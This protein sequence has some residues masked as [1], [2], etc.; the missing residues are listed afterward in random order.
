VNNIVKILRSFLPYGL[1]AWSR[2]RQKAKNREKRTSY[3]T[4]NS[5]KIFYITGIVDKRGGLFWML[6]YNLSR[7]AY[8]LEKGWIPVVDWQNRPNQYL[9]NE[10]LYKENAWEYYF[11]QPCNYN[12]ASINRSKNII[13]DHRIDGLILDYHIETNEEYFSYL[14]AIFKK[15]IRFN[16]FTHNYIEK[17]YQTILK[18][19]DKILGVLCRGTDYMHKKPDGHPI[20]PEPEKVIKKAKEVMAD[21]QLDYIYL[22][23]EDQ[24]IYEL[25]RN[26]F[27]EKVLTNRQNRFTKQEVAK[28]QYLYQIKQ[29][30]ENDKYWLG[31]EYLSSMYLLSKC[32]S[33]ISGR[34]RGATGVLL[35]TDGFDYRYIWNLGV[36]IDE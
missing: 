31:L 29:D 24:D 12:L 22:A 18:D 4:E 35:M 23:T 7:I 1:V 3:G 21:Q 36:Y 13:Q 32:N 15:Y 8:A 17:E 16:E 11:E 27:G 28:V 19:K 34:T 6:L 33:F 25:F 20:Q 26:E 5:D 2:K 14:K 9:E 10:K 30:R